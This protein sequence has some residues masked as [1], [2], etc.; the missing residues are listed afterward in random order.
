[1]SD[2]SQGPGWWL[3][4][5]G[6][7]YPPEQSTAPAF[8]A[9]VQPEASSPEPKRNKGLHWRKMTWAVLVF[10]LIMLIWLITSLTASTKNCN[11]MTTGECAG[12]SDVAHSAV[13]AI[14]IVLWVF[15]DII[16][17]IIWLVIRGVRVRCVAVASSV[18]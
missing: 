3:A 8:V 9:T 14:Q 15:G 6:R 11:G 4:S 1:M 5:D 13:A 18:D 16:L 17:G 12:V 10:N 7:W 2:T